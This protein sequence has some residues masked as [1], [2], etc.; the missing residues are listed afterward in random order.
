[1][2]IFLIVARAGEHVQNVLHRL[3]GAHAVDRLAHDLNSLLLLRLQQQ[4]VAPRSRLHN[5]DGREHAF[6]GKLAV[7]HQLHV[8]GS[9][10][11]LE[12]HVIHLASG[13]HQRSG[14][15]CETSSIT[16]VSGRTEKALRHVQRCRIKT[17][18]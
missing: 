3:V 13:I 4:I 14:K 15:D 5:V 6:L 17:S 12:H 11:L 9:L 1:M 10:K 18:G 8:A 7:K 2:D 16:H